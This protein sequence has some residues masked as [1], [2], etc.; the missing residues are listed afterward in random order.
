[1]QRCRSAFSIVIFSIGVYWAHT[2][3]AQ[4]QKDT[5]STASQP[6][7]VVSNAQKWQYRTDR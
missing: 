5:A 3:G 2:V 4:P 1:M 6:T 7:R